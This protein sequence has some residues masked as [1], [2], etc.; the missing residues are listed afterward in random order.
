MRKSLPTL[1]AA[2]ALI[3]GC[4]QADEAFDKNF[5]ESCV[6][7]ATEAGVPAAVAGKVCDCTLTKINEKF[8]TS[9]K[10]TMSPQDAQPMMVA[11]MNEA[12]ES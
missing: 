9:E 4:G 10:L 2:A 7:S 8:S 1:I 11:C 3:A 6:S 12:M 5:A